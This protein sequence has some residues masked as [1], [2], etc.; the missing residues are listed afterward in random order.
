MHSRLIFESI[1]NLKFSNKFTVSKCSY[2]K[3][4]SKSLFL[5]VF[6]KFKD[7]IVLYS[8]ALVCRLA[9]QNILVGHAQN[10]VRTIQINAH[11]MTNAEYALA[12]CSADFS[13]VCVIVSVFVLEAL[14]NPYPNSAALKNKKPF[15]HAFLNTL[16]MLD[17]IFHDCALVTFI[18]LVYLYFPII[19]FW[20]FFAHCL[21]FIH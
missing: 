2:D 17:H 10:V 1:S 18:V 16:A 9:L 12:Q 3:N 8:R 13:I 6:K 20:N 4:D 7:A 11:T 14:R 5:I 15:D 21:Y 19:L